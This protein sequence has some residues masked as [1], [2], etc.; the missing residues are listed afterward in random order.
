M[1]DLQTELASVKILM[2]LKHCMIR[3]SLLAVAAVLLLK[4]FPRSGAKTVELVE[5]PVGLVCPKDHSN[6]FLFLALPVVFGAPSVV[7]TGI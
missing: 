5:Q 6:P 3:F 4:C 2:N 7:N 1:A